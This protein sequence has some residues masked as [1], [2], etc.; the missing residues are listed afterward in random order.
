MFTFN[1]IDGYAIVD[2]KGTYIYDITPTAHGIAAISSDD[3]LRLLDPLAL[4]KHALSTVPRQNAEFTCLRALDEE[5]AIV[6]T[7]GRDGSICAFDLRNGD[8]VL[9]VKSDQNAPILS[10]ACL[11]PYGLAGGTELTNHEATVL[12]WDMRQP[13][14]PQVKYVESHSD[15]ITELQFHPTQNSLL[16][17]G[18][19]DGLV[20][21][22]NTTISDEEEALHQ[23][24]NLGHSIHRANFLSDLDIFALSHDEKFA[25][26]SLVTDAREEV[27]E[28]PPQ[29]FG[30]I[31]ERIGG[32]YVANV[33]KRG[34]GIAAMGIGIHSREEFDLVQFKNSPP[35]TVVQESKVTLRGAHGSEIVRSFCFL[36]QHQLVLTAG[37]DGQV[38]AWRGY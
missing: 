1:A 30:D 35:W 22:Y 7:G 10:L 38:K 31:R 17:S 37:E 16:L 33:I 13:A 20:N 15:D 8:K 23:T 28:K 12:L 29:D 21:I 2:P 36:D 18:S 34:A 26:Y 24:I 6:C 32:E 14:A 9:E 3:K 27:E 25:I 11:A 5:N 4:S 19:T